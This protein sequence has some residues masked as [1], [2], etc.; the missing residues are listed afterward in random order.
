LEEASRLAPQLDALNLASRRPSPFDTFAYLKTFL[1]HDEHRPAERELLLLVAF[2]GDVPV[3][4]IALC[5][6][7]ESVLGLRC[8]AIRFL[9]GHDNDRPHVI[10]RAE[11]EPSACEAFYRYLLQDDGW[12]LLLL[13]EQ[14]A[15]SGLSRSPPDLDPRNYYVRAW[16]TNPNATISVT[17]RCL[18][19]YL[20]TFDKK[21]RHNLERQARKL[22]AAGPLEYVSSS[23]AAGRAELFDVYLDL[24]QRSW[25]AP[26][27]AHIGRHPERVVFFR[28]L[29]GPDQPMPIAVDLLLLDGVP[30]A[31]S[32]R[33]TF[34]EGMFVLEIAYDDAYRDL[35]PGNVL[36]LLL[37]HGAI[38]RGERFVNLL[39]NYAYYKSRWLATITETYAVQVYRRPSL[40]YYKA[41]AGAI[42]R[43]ISSPPITQMEASRNLSKPENSESRGA[44]ERT[45]MRAPRPVERERARTALRRIEAAGAGLARLSGREIAAIMPFVAKPRMEPT[46]VC[47][48]PPCASTPGDAPPAAGH[49]SPP[50]RA[51][52]FYDSSDP[53]RPRARVPR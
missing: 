47:E 30:V 34:G 5:R 32:V 29:L 35:A 39:G 25:K 46:T 14:D 22:L 8:R 23:D 15:S 2:D 36:W 44:G 1:E 13:Q 9:V 10:A 48:A 4:Y 21:H 16:P 7:E 33:G 41:K 24:E 49:D 38:E 31:G 42:W 52:H 51:E 40:H 50:G 26:A 37:I 11:D 12:T 27:K 45:S 19:E 53:P 18:A 43:Q 20:K 3:A 28:R 17:Q 6:V